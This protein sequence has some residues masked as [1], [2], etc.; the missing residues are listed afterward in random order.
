MVWFGEA[1]GR[2]IT[3]M[4]GNVQLLSLTDIIN[5]SRSSFAPI[6]LYYSDS[7][8]AVIRDMFNAEAVVDVALSLEEPIAGHENNQILGK[9]QTKAY[10]PD[11]DVEGKPIEWDKKLIESF[12]V[13][14]SE[15]ES[16]SLEN[17]KYSDV[18][19]K[20]NMKVPIIDSV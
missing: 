6:E 13:K 19:V 20:F 2:S 7:L 12:L 10:L 15:Q 5:T 16:I 17:I 8:S 1:T 11:S 4:S 9:V 3:I 14:Y 18:I